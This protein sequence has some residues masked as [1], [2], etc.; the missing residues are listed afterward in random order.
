MLSQLIAWGGITLEVLLLLRGL[1]GKLAFRYPVFYA[2]FS[3]VVLQDLLSFGVYRWYHQYYPTVYWLTEF[4]ALLFGCGV[5]FE[6]YRVGLS[7]FP[8]TAR[9]ARN[10]LALV[11]AAALTFGLAQ[12]WT[13]PRWWMEAATTDIEGAL[14][15]VEALAIVVLAALFLLYSIPVGKN[16]R[17]ILLGYGLFVGTTVLSLEFVSG[18]GTAF[19][20][21]LSAAY[22][23][24]YFLSLTL[25]VAHLW[26][27]APNPVPAASVRLEREYQRMAAA[28]H[29]RLQDARGYLA[30]AV[31]P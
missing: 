18:S 2:Y 7:A 21:F 12:A 25:W 9:M 13:D 1:K 19:H 15:A 23:Y 17:G 20:H 22:P 4:L 16:L 8:G 14:R 30:K 10:A 29:R 6:I 28:T 11:F 26:S 5:V 3:F 24:F 27:Y 31:R